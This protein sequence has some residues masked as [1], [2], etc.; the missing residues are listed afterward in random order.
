[1]SGPGSKQTLKLRTY[2]RSTSTRYDHSKHGQRQGHAA[3]RQVDADAPTDDDARTKRHLNFGTCTCMHI[4]IRAH[5]PPHAASSRLAR[6]TRNLERELVAKML[7]RSGNAWLPLLLLGVPLLLQLPATAAAAGGGDASAEQPVY[8]YGPSGAQDCP[9]LPTG[10]VQEQYLEASNATWDEEQQP[11]IECALRAVVDGSDAGCLPA[12]FGEG[13]CAPWNYAAFA[14]P[15]C[16]SS[17]GAAGDGENTNGQPC[18]AAFCLVDPANCARPHSRSYY[19][20]EL[21][22]STANVTAAYAYS[23]ATC[24]WTDSSIHRSLEGEIRG[25]RVRVS[26][27]AADE[28]F[29]RELSGGRHGGAAG[30]LF[31]DIAVENG[32]A[33]DVVAVP[34]A[35]VERHGSSYEACVRAVALN[36]TDLCV[37]AFWQYPTRASMVEF[38]ASFDTENMYLVTRSAG[39]AG[40]SFSGMISRPFLPFSRPAWAC[41]IASVVAAALAFCAIEPSALEDAGWDQSQQ[42]DE[43][44]GAAIVRW[45]SLALLSVHVGLSS[46]FN[47]GSEYQPRTPAGRLLHIGFALFVL[48]TISSYTANLATYLIISNEATTITDLEDAVRKRVPVCG[49]GYV[50]ETLFALHPGLE[51]IYVPASDVLAAV[52][53]GNCTAAIVTDNHLNK[54]KAREPTQH[55]DKVIVGGVVAS[56]SLAWPLNSEMDKPISTAILERLLNGRYNSFRLLA[57]QQYGITKDTCTASD[58]GTGLSVTEIAGIVAILGMFMVAAFLCKLICSSRSLMTT[59]LR[60]RRYAA[61]TQGKAICCLGNKHVRDDSHDTDQ[62]PSQPQDTQVEMPDSPILQHKQQDSGEKPA[63]MKMDSAAELSAV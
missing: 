59:R 20:T 55:C 49:Y 18:G 57:Q 21:V 39:K 9:C 10:S 41:I 61:S 48:V 11:P 31:Q 4:H 17:S 23:Y 30:E 35:L 34:P 33:V 43:G 53:E 22:L 14:S 16:G 37:G 62:R 36:E 52:D 45:L 29:L 63:P 25:A 27:P 6:T 1:M 58:S 19:G 3:H 15:S 28:F 5:L 32:V 7:L 54:R 42:P 40:L 8:L 51:S 50:K 56:W 46:F 60:R 12:G 2:T 13:S 38:T 44:C 24:G 26:Y 47:A